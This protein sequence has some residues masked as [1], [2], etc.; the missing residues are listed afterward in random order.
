MRSWCGRRE[1][2]TCR[3]G[4]FGPAVRFDM[5]RAWTLAETL[6][7]SEDNDADDGGERGES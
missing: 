5:A 6:S 2:K 4:N 7:A 1:K 3:V